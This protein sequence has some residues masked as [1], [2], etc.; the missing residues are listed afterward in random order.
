MPK[1]AF[2]GNNLGR[3][4]T[5]GW[6]FKFQYREAML[7]DCVN[8]GRKDEIMEG[9]CNTTKDNKILT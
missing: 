4:Q 1:T 6:S 9:L 5:S 2:S 8:S 3:T 7:E